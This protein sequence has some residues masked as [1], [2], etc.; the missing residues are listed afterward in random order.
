[1][2][3]YVDQEHTLSSSTATFMIG[4]P[5]GLGKL[6]DETQT[7]NGGS[8]F[9]IIMPCVNFTTLSYVATLISTSLE[10]AIFFNTSLHSASLIPCSV[11][12]MRQ[13]QLEIWLGLQ[14]KPELK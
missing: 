1:M 10:F 14:V 12:L 13:M 6:N 5:N 11:M 2:V 4:D 8:P 7:N 9:D 3:C